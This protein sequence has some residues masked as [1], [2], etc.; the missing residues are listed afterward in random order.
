MRLVEHLVPIYRVINED[1]TKDEASKRTRKNGEGLGRETGEQDGA[2]NRNEN[3]NTTWTERGRNKNGK[4]AR[5]TKICDAIM[6]KN[7]TPLILFR[8]TP[9]PQALV[10]SPALYYPPPPGVGRAGGIGRSALFLGCSHQ[11]GP[12]SPR[13]PFSVAHP[14]MPPSPRLAGRQEKRPPPPTHQGIA[15]HQ[16]IH[17]TPRSLDKQDKAKD[18]TR[19]WHAVLIHRPTQS[20]LPRVARRVRRRPAAYRPQGFPSQGG[21]NSPG[22]GIYSAPFSSAH[23]IRPGSSSHPPHGSPFHPDGQAGRRAVLGPASYH[24]PVSSSPRL[25]PRVGGRGEK[26]LAP[27]GRLG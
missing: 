6:S 12:I 15:S 23:L 13:A 16:G 18:G 20:P 1:G 22:G 17:P 2:K 25:V 5:T 27:V 9:S 8:P 24:R 10:G 14:S 7:K 11:P 26:R 19:G 21:G 4:Q 3:G